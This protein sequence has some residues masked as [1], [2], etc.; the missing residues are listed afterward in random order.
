MSLQAGNKIIEVMTKWAKFPQPKSIT[1]RV[2]LEHKLPA[3]NAPPWRCRLPA[4]PLSQLPLGQ[5]FGSQM[6][7]AFPLAA[8]PQL[9]LEERSLV[10]TGGVSQKFLAIK[11]ASIEDAL[12]TS[13]GAQWRTDIWL[14]NISPEYGCNSMLG[15]LILVQSYVQ[16]ATPEASSGD[17]D[18][19]LKTPIMP[20]SDFSTMLR[21]VT[22]L[23]TPESAAAFA[24][25][26]PQ[27]LP[28]L[29]LVMSK[30]NAE[31]KTKNWFW[32][33]A[34]G[35]ELRLPVIEWLQGLCAQPGKDQIAIND[36][37]ARNAQIGGLGNKVERMIGKEGKEN[38]P[39]CPILEF[40]SL[41]S[42]KWIQVA[43][44]A[45]AIFENPEHVNY[46]GGTSILQT[47]EQWVRDH[48]SKA[49]SFYSRESTPAAT[50]ATGP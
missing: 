2:G 5:D 6:T 22:D 21:L 44:Q 40:R 28:M 13:W 48:H 15:F 3:P 35:T 11:T 25:A 46:E 41:G 47:L 12:N 4:T 9:L 38:V 43:S 29:M 20:R 49:S 50:K 36:G 34:N 30:L 32:N 27:S 18:L 1:M 16:V 24:T 33:R 45:P 26:S 8:V 31:L 42:L 39:L 19:K 10:L 23:M 17:N 37:L 7:A 14:S